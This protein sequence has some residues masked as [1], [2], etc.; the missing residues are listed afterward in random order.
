MKDLRTKAGQATV[1]YVLVF[2]GFLSLVLALGALWRFVQEGSLVAH[3]L[4]S[5]P[6]LVQGC[7][8]WVADIFAC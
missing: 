3:A 8:G 7:A 1:E 6:Y 2:A 5:S 4:Y